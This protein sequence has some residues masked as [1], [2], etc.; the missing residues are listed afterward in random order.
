MGSEWLPL[1]P[2]ET[3]NMTIT[4]YIFQWSGSS[5]EQARGSHLYILAFLDPWLLISDDL[6]S[7]HVLLHTTLDSGSC[8]PGNR[9]YHQWFPQTLMSAISVV[10]FL[11]W[12]WLF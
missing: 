2:Q 7:M 12:W 9:Y 11:L 3:G 8:G 1:I 4:T 5:L 10:F 6:E